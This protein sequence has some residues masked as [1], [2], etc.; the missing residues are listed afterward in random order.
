MSSFSRRSPEANP[1]TSVNS[2]PTQRL[3]RELDTVVR[4]VQSEPIIIPTEKE[5][6]RDRERESTSKRWE[7]EAPTDS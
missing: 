4:T 3:S 2:E 1:I 6:T 5:V 7:E